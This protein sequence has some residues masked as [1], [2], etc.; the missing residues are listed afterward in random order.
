MYAIKFVR[1]LN[2][3]KLPQ[4][5]IDRIP[6]NY[7]LYEKKIQGIKS[8]HYVW[9]DSHNQEVDAWCKENVCDSMYYAY[10]IISGNMVLHKD[11][12]TKIKFIYLLDA[13]GSDVWTEFYA[14][15]QC[16]LL[17]RE[18]LEINRWYIMKVDVYHKVVGIDPGNVRFG[19]TGR[20]FE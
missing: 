12:G 17:Q 1:C 11:Q 6:R 16:T 2:L 3:P 7:S 8:V 9:T 15:D 5:I 14:D 10:Q 4:D 20:V 19:I 13:G 18:K